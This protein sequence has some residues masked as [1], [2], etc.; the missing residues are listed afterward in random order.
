[1]KFTRRHIAALNYATL[2]SSFILISLFQAAPANAQTKNQSN[3]VILLYHHVSAS[4]PASTSVPP[5]IFKEHMTYLA[6]HYS[7][8]PLPVIVN[9]IKNSKP[10]PDKAIAVTFD[11]GFENILTNGHSVM[12]ALSLPY[13]IFINPAEIGRQKSQLNW[14]QVKK[15]HEEGV[16]FANHT[17]DHLHMLD[18]LNG[19]SEA[20]WLDRVWKN[21]EEAEAQIREHTGESLKYLAYPFGEFNQQLANRVKQAGYIGFGQHSGGVGPHSDF[22][23]LPRFPAAGP[24]A[25]MSSLKVKMASLAMPV[26]SQTLQNPEFAANTLVGKQSITVRQ[27]DVR[28]KQAACYFQGETLPVDFS[29]NTLSYTLDKALPIGRSRVN[30]TAPSA[31]KPGRYYWYSQPFFVARENGTYPD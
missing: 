9:A 15:L 17:L 11:D 2:I 13:T 4:T 10:L 27:E 8:L 14:E 3:A 7:V 12:N 16:D 25:R 20:A 19:E 28:L 30:C 31:S 29:D 23:A 6:E 18:R 26:L 24:Y 1:M 21:V 22:A 5:E